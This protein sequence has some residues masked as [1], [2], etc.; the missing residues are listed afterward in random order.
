MNNIVR[1]K[2]NWFTY[3]CVII[4]DMKHPF[5]SLCVLSTK[6]LPFYFDRRS[7]WCIVKFAT[8]CLYIRLS[9]HPSVAKMDHL[10]SIWRVG[11]KTSRKAYMVGLVWNKKSH[12]QINHK[13]IQVGLIK[14]ERGDI[15]DK[16]TIGSSGP[17]SLT[18]E[19]PL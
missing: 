8:S 14:S 11:H 18:W 15:P 10:T 2:V 4:Y 1:R 9:R 19:F 3:F 17:V 16:I 6:Y 5:S 7:Y 13:E 12:G